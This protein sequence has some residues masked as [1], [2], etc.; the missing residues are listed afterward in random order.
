[1]LSLRD[2][3]TA[4]EDR[5]AMM[6]EPLIER[7]PQIAGRVSRQRPFGDRIAIENA[8]RME[9][10]ALD[11]S[12]MIELFRAHPELS[13]DNP[14]AMT[15]D[16]QSE[17]GRLNLTSQSHDYRARLAELNAAYTSRFGFPFITALVLHN[18]IHS[19]LAEFE[20]RLAATRDEEVRRA[21]DQICHVSAA[22]IR[23]AFSSDTSAPPQV[24]AD[25]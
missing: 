20:A 14:M 17:Q 21:I 10:L 15:P 6:L 4:S 7:A 2:L 22:R 12:D 9:L 23:K 19:V 24:D 11:E 3:N 1:M 13:P 8:I 16:S 25:R 5:A 18:D